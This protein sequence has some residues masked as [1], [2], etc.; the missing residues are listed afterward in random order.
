MLYYFPFLLIPKNKYLKSYS[1]SFPLFI[2]RAEEGHICLSRSYL[3]MVDEELKLTNRTNYNKMVP[4]KN[5][6]IYCY[7]DGETYK[8]NE[9]CYASENYHSYDYYIYDYYYQD[10]YDDSSILCTLAT[11]E[12]IQLHPQ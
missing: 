5:G 1:Q 9:L 3:N 12:K 6:K 11:G 2:Y 10:Y 7:G 4:I 8:L